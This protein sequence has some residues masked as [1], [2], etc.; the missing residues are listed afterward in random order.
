MLPI[1]TVLYLL[2]SVIESTGHL[3]RW[4]VIVTQPPLAQ[5][6]V[7]SRKYGIPKIVGPDDRSRTVGGSTV[8]RRKKPVAMPL[9]TPTTTGGS[10]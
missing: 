3:L 6:I 5:E 4:S 7:A 8:D 1:V 9:G 10:R 2:C